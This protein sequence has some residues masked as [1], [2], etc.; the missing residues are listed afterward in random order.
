MFIDLHVKYPLFLSDFNETWTFSTDLRKISKYQIT[1]KSV[2]WEPS[3]SMRTDRHYE[4]HCR[5]SQFCERASKLFRYALY[6]TV[7]FRLEIKR[8]LTSIVCIHSL[9]SIFVGHVNRIHSWAAA[10]CPGGRGVCHQVCWCLSQKVMPHISYCMLFARWI[11]ENFK[12]R[13]C[14]IAV[15]TVSFQ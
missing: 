7:F 1:W 4:A 2:H 3:C 5:F 8:F 14:N 13:H 9:N 15:S 11:R 6:M 12:E 10:W